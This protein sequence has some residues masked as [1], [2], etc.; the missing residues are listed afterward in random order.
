MF[1]FV[2][3]VRERHKEN[4]Q[5]LAAIASARHEAERVGDEPEKT[6]ADTVFEAYD[7]FPDGGPV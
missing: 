3:R 1:G 7:K 5:E 2:K 6:M 4:A